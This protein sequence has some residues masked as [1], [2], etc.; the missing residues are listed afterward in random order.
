MKK[1]ITLFLI[2]FMAFSCNEDSFLKETPLDFMSGNNSYSTKA[3]YDASIT[4]LYYLTRK[5]FF[6]DY[7]RSMDFIYGTDL[8]MASDP[9]KANL[10]SDYNPT[11]GIAKFHWET[12]Y[13]LVAQSNVA[14]S[15]L[16]ESELTDTQKVEYE[17]KARFFRGFA[18]R[19][20]AY[21]YGGVPLQLEEVKSQRLTMYVILKKM[22]LPRQ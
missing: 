8:M 14:I 3:D 11:G 9:L 5:E 4:E 18:Y 7:N 1:Y 19:T 13:L 10:S 2:A 15:R 17:A 12:L 22:Y 6:G 20:L 16:P 21:L